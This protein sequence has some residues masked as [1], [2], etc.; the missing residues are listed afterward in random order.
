MKG[1][2]LLEDGTIFYGKII[3][4]TKNI[5]GKVTLDGQDSI[6]LNCYT[7]DNQ[8]I[9]VSSQ[10]TEGDMILSDIDFQSLKLRIE[11]NDSLQGKIV[12]DSL[13]IEYHVYD[14]KTFIPHELH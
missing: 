5:L 14:V 3:S 1:Y 11:K 9:V 12:T 6:S 2:L 8:G 13:P 10:Q 7:T 4:E